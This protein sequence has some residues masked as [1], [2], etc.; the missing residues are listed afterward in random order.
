[1]RLMCYQS[2]MMA[3]IILPVWALTSVKKGGLQRQR[4]RY[5]GKREEQ[6]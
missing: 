4:A 3:Q 6:E 1:M 5:T 2:F